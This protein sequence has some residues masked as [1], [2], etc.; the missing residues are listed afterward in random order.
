MLIY[1]LGDRKLS[2]LTATY[3][4]SEEYGMLSMVFGQQG[5]P[6]WTVAIDD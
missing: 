2:A 5:G 1:S 4:G 6:T 3:A